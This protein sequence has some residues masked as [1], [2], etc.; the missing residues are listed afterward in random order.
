MKATFEE[1]T[2]LM[3]DA[4][5]VALAAGWSEEPE[6]DVF[7]LGGQVTLSLRIKNAAK[8]AA[9]IGTLPAMYRPAVA[10]LDPTGKLEVKANGEITSKRSAVELETATTNQY[11]LTY[12]AAGISP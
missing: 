12:R 2:E 8:A 4:E 9:L 7:R 10:L 11:L 5:T 1:G 6:S 3:E